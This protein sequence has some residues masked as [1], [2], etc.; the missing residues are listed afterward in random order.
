MDLNVTLSSTTSEL[1][2]LQDEIEQL[3]DK[4]QEWKRDHRKV[5]GRKDSLLASVD[6]LKE[7]L[8]SQQK[9]LHELIKECEQLQV[10][11]AFR[12]RNQAWRN[13][14]FTKQEHLRYLFNQIS[15][16]AHKAIEMKERA[17]A[18]KHEICPMGE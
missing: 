12:D 13:K 14:Y 11:V 2:K 1:K 17:M 5:K 4:L 18:L 9:S 10:Y 7:Q 3:Q 16:V 6:Q 15:M 8:H